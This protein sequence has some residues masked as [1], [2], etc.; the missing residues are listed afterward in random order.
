MISFKDRND[1]ILIW[2]AAAVFSSA[3]L[4]SLPGCGGGT[5]GTGIGDQSLAR[6]QGTVV[7]REGV[8][9]PEFEFIVAG[10]ETTVVTELDGSFE[11]EVACPAAGSAPDAG[12]A[13]SASADAP[14][15]DGGADSEVSVIIADSGA[16]IDPNPSDPFDP[17]APIPIEPGIGDG[18]SLEDP[19][20]QAGGSDEPTT[21][22]VQVGDPAGDSQPRDQ[23]G[24]DQSGSDSAG[25]VVPEN[26][27][28]QT[29]KPV[30][31]DFSEVCAV[32]SAEEQ[33]GAQAAPAE[34]AAAGSAGPET[35]K[36]E[37][38]DRS[39]DSNYSA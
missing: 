29:A 23:A 38:S 21:V 2:T 12:A 30:E 10:T 18:S 31:V 32:K 24:N 4:V 27:G 5:S 34:A 33:T 37:N 7:S 19:A 39:L 35:K 9:L 26:S 3:I 6:V 14:V 13:G 28:D 8:P 11:A 15:S 17:D 25:T 1:R 22:I 36:S 16:L 20:P